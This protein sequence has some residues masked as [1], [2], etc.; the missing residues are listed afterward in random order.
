M[1]LN[2]FLKKSSRDHEE[3]AKAQ[4]LGVLI[5]PQ[6]GLGL[7]FAEPHT[8][9]LSDD[10][11]SIS[12]ITLQEASQSMR[13][14]RLT[15]NHREVAQR[16]RNKRSLREV[17]AKKPQGRRQQSIVVMKLCTHSTTKA[18]DVVAACVAA[19]QRSTVAGTP[20][21]TR[22]LSAQGN[23]FCMSHENAQYLG[24]CLS[25]WERGS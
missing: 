8:D 10:S 17:R 24:W 11:L 3:I 13:L 6:L 4:L 16:R 21:V 23:P 2:R 18:V 9:N 5:G 12:N 14:I 15:N 1:D 19:A 22:R 25:M 20:E 7:G